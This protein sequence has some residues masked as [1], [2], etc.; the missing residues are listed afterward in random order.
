[1][2]CRTFDERLQLQMDARRPVSLDAESRLHLLTCNA[3]EEVFR[4]Y[5]EMDGLFGAGGEAFAQTAYG[6]DGTSRFDADREESA[7]LEPVLAPVIRA[8]KAEMSHGGSIRGSSVG[9][10]RTVQSPLTS[11]VTVALERRNGPGNLASGRWG[12]AGMWAAAALILA[13]PL[14]AMIFAVYQKNN[15]VDSA[16][17]SVSSGPDGA[18]ASQTPGRVPSG[19]ALGADGALPGS[20]Q[21]L[22]REDFEAITEN[23]DRGV[24]TFDRG[25]QKLAFGRV[26]AHQLPGVQPAVYPITGVVE[27]FRRTMIV[28]NDRGVAAGVRW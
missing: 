28:R 3:C 4:F 9:L 20:G 13:L 16:S 22:V 17:L 21:G 14:S 18:F 6:T 1:M 8:G 11:S 12:M 19:P 5:A 7:A 25:W 10:R 2:D 26:R 23:L 15:A 24:V 27:A